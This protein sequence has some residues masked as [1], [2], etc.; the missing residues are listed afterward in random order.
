M[1]K[2]E[3]RPGLLSGKNRWPDLNMRPPVYYPGVVEFGT[4]YG[5]RTRVTAVRGQ[6]PGPL[7][8]RGAIL[9]DFKWPCAGVNLAESFKFRKLPPCSL[10]VLLHKL[11]KQQHFPLIP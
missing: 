3:A 11:P 10:K 5:S 1:G 9:H 7:D 2:R 4:A 6:R 8:E